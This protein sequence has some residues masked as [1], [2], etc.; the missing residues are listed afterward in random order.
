[1]KLTLPRAHSAGV[2]SLLHL[3]LKLIHNP[4]AELTLNSLL[5][6]DFHVRVLSQIKIGRLKLAIYAIV[7]IRQKFLKYKHKSVNFIVSILLFRVASR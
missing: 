1:M 7:Q 3:G 4:W 2:V 6:M 5:Y